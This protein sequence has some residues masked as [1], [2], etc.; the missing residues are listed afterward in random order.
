MAASDEQKIHFLDP[1]INLVP[2]GIKKLDQLMA[3]IIVAMVSKQFNSNDDDDHEKDDLIFMSLSL[4]PCPWLLCLC[5]SFYLFF[6]IKRI[7][8]NDPLNFMSALIPSFFKWRVLLLHS[9][10]GSSKYKTGSEMLKG[11]G[12]QKVLQKPN[13]VHHKQRF[14]NNNNSHRSMAKRSGTKL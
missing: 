5:P 1:I 11:K 7:K 8:F 10:T 13:F 9:G 4:S 3:A 12:Q 6:K 2:N 14:N